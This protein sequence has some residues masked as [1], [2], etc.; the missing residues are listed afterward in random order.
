MPPTKNTPLLN[1]KPN[2]PRVV[3]AV[4][5]QI[6]TMPFKELQERLMHIDPEAT[7]RAAVPPPS[8]EDVAVDFAKD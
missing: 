4:L 1:L 8:N 6:E 2:D 7:P 3:A 5:Q